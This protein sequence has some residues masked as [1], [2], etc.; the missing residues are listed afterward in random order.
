[1]PESKPWFLR[2]SY[3][4]FKTPKPLYSE[5]VYRSLS[6]DAKVLYS[7]LLDRSSLSYKNREKW[8]LPNGTV[9]V[10]FTQAE[11]C[12]KLGCGHD[13]A[14]KL[15]KELELYHLIR[16]FYGKAGSPAKIVVLP[17]MSTDP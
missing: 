16:R 14:A 6:S 9:Y 11:I 8:S 7:L 13:K 17:F 10:I 4:F 1:M 12:Q 5:E 2:V 15:M 3:P